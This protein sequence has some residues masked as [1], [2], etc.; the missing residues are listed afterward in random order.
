MLL[1]S[2]TA[3]EQ[4]LGYSLVEVLVAI[5]ILLLATVGPMTIAARSMQ[6]A[7]YA[8]EQNTAFFLAQEGIEAFYKVRADQGL[9]HFSNPTTESSWGWAAV[10]ALSVCRAGGCGI[11]WSDADITSGVRDCTSNVENCRV[12]VDS[13]GDRARYSHD[14]S[15]DPTPFVRI[16]TLDTVAPDTVQV[17]SEVR[18]TSHAGN[19]DRTVIL[20]T[21]LHDIYD[22]TN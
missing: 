1:T 20:E 9:L 12:Y 18:W 16:L 6:Y 14:A 7:Q 19:E 4:T 11:D 15:G 5:S 10:S 21:Y 3:T 17:H 2:I 8:A 22:T 13:S